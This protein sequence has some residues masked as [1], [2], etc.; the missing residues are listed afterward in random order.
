MQED[1]GRVYGGPSEVVRSKL[2]QEPEKKREKDLRGE[3]LASHHAKGRK[4]AVSATVAVL[5]KG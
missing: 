4:E 1:S 2:A 5:P 3:E